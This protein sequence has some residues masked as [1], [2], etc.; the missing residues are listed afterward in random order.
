MYSNTIQKQ[1]PS[2]LEPGF[3]STEKSLTNLLVVR[4]DDRGMTSLQ[5]FI[6]SDLPDGHKS[7]A[8]HH[9]VHHVG[10]QDQSQSN[11]LSPPESNITTFMVFGS[12][13]TSQATKTQDI[14]LGGVGAQFWWYPGP[15]SNEHPT[16]NTGLSIM[17][18]DH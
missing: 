17:E 9:S 13:D 15:E 4:E 18:G 8:R 10:V 2:G 7:S 14:D 12:L 6:A 11:E 5:H 3:K 16:S 1:Q